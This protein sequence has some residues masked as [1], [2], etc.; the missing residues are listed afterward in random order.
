MFYL[1]IIFNTSLFYIFFNSFIFNTLDIIPI[2]SAVD[3]IKKFLRENPDLSMDIK[4]EVFGVKLFSKKKF[5]L[6]KKFYALGEEEEDQNGENDIQSFIDSEMNE[7]EKYKNE[8]QEKFS[9]RHRRVL[10]IGFSQRSSSSR[11]RS[12]SAS[13]SPAGRSLGCSPASFWEKMI[14]RTLAS[15]SA[16]SSG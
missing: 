11:A 2:N 12:S 3:L 16:V 7:C 10:T 1:F 9:T 6:L 4:R 15:I 5:N 13:F 14:S 8:L